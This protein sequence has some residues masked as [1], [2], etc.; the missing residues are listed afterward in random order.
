MVIYLDWNVLNKIEKRNELTDDESTI[1]KKL[2]V[3]LLT[4][5]VIVPYSNAHLND[6]LRGAKKSSAFIAGHLNILTLLTKS[7]CV[8]QYWN[9]TRPVF[10]KRSVVEFF[11]TS[12]E[13]EQDEYETYE[14]LINADFEISEGIPFKPLLFGTSHLKFQ[15]VPDSFKLIYKEDPIF[16]IMYPQTKT[17]MTQYSLCC[18]IFHFYRLLKTDYSIYRALKKFLLQ[19]VKKYKLNS[20]PLRLIQKKG[21]VI[22]RHLETD[23]DLLFEQIIIENNTGVSKTYNIFFETFFRHDLKGYKSDHRFPNMIDDAL[24]SYYGAHCDYFITNDD[25]CLYKAAKTYERLGVTTSV[26][27]AR[28]FVMKYVDN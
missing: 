12:F 25:N 6:L 1:Y 2:L 3:F 14:D 27:T 4:S 16:S 20:E 17:E 9:E 24:H 8:C 13:D 23:M 10:H 21:D 22:P 26:L 7:I 28:D 19:S 15:P 18:D 5:N 11:Q